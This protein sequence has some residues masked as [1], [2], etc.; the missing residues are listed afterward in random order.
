MIGIFLGVLYEM[1]GSIWPCVILHTLNNFV[2]MVQSFVP[3]KF[4]SYFQGVLVSTLI[5]L[6]ILL[7]GVISLGI[8]LTRFFGKKKDCKDGVFGKDLVTADGYAA[9]PLSAAKL[10]SL[11][12]KG[13]MKAFVIISVIESLLIVG[14]VWLY[15]DVV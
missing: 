2:S 5:D 14:V 11:F 10:R 6:A 15:D 7:M 3:Y 12:W 9:V 13:T 4:E 8:L 1:S